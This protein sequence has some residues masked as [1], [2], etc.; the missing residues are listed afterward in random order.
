MDGRGHFLERLKSFRIDG[1]PQRGGKTDTA[2]QSQLVFGKAL[3]RLTYRAND[4]VLQILLTADIIED[5]LFVWIIE[6]RVDREITALGILAR[7][8]V[9]NPRWMAPIHIRL[10]GAEGGHFK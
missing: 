8:S 10:V 3:C 5:L 2:Q 6:K 1:K 4:L 9:V 7:R